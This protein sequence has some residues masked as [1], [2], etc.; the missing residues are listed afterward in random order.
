MSVLFRI[1]QPHIQ[2]KESFW[3][4]LGEMT[5]LE[6][7]CILS[8]SATFTQSVVEQFVSKVRALTLL[9]RALVAEIGETAVESGFS[10]VQEHCFHS[11]Q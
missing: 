1:E 4:A 5:S 7:V 6:R 3:A 2:L 9:S 8:K 11:L 10:F